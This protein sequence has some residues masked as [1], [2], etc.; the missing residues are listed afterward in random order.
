MFYFYADKTGKL[1][2][3]K[4][5]VPLRTK[6][7]FADLPSALEKSPARVLIVDTDALPA[8]PTR[9]KVG[10]VSLYEALEKKNKKEVVVPRDSIRYLSPYQI[11]VE[12]AAVGWIIIRAKNEKLQILL[13][14]RRGVWDLPKG[15]QDPGE[16]ISQCAKREVKEELGISRVKIVKALDVSVHVY[17]ENRRFKVKTTHWFQMKTRDRNFTPEKREGIKEVK[18]FSWSKA[19][20]IVGYKNL[21]KLLQR[22][23]PLVESDTG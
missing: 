9:T 3:R 20:K 6:R 16:S 5:G 4:K 15:K 1:D 23:R 22:T 17:S 12:I 2:E 13:I 14:L 8:T 11:P 18:W 10:E 19:E 7:L 21:R